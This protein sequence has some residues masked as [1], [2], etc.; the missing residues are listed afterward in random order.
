MVFE[1]QMHLTNLLTRFGWEVRVAQYALSA[2]EKDSENKIGSLLRNGAQE[3]VDSLLFTYEAP[4]T[5]KSGSLRCASKEAG[6]TAL[7][8][9]FLRHLYWPRWQNFIFGALK[10]FCGNSVS[11]G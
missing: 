3:L 8:G 2:G 1:H 6:A 5:S 11:I 4:I 9:A 7:A 10:F